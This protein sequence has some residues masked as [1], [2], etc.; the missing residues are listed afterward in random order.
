MTKTRLQRF[1]SIATWSG[2][3]IT[4]CGIALNLASGGSWWSN[5]LS[6]F[7]VL[8]TCCGHWISGA[9]AKHQAQEKAADEERLAELECVSDFLNKAG[10][11]DRPETLKR[12]IREHE[13]NF[14]VEHQDDGR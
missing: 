5:G 4:L 13:M 7:G 11:F 1:K 12:M 3:A 2:V 14:D 9:L 8:I 10:V 6:S